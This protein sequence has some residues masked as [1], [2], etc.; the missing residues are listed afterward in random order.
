MCSYWGVF[1]LCTK[2]IKLTYEQIVPV[3]SHISSSKRWTNFDYVWYWNHAKSFPK[4]LVIAFSSVLYTRRWLFMSMGWDYYVSELRVLTGLLFIPRWY[5]W[6]WRTTVELYRQ[7]KTD[8]ST[9]NPTSSHL[10]ASRRNGRRNDEFGL[11][12]YFC[13]YLPSDF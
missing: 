1:I 5:I 12:K 3:C 7:R 9:S 10:E 11:S 6:P 13:S 8:S 2:C 4:I